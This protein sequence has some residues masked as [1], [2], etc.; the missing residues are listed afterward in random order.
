MEGN[1]TKK[2]CLLPTDSVVKS[3]FTPLAGGIVV[4]V[5]KTI[6]IIFEYARLLW[7]GQCRSPFL[8]ENDY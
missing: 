6:Q 1:E 8:S 4:Q 7:V 5:W 3:Q 2:N